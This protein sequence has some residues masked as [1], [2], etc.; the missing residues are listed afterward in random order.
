[1]NAPELENKLGPLH[2]NTL[3]LFGI[4]TAQHMVEHLTITLKLSSGRINYPLFTPTEQQIQWK[5]S[6]LY[7]DMEFPKAIKAPGLKDSLMPL[8][9]QSLEIAKVQL[10]NSITEYNA[11][12]LENPSAKTNH[13]RFGMLNHD[14]W[15]LFHPKHFK[16]HFGQFNIW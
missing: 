2:E 15:E 9:Y 10:I 3:P 12:F 6:L 4:M 7:T 13:P 8:K 14:E 5:E 16:H 1:M 11:F